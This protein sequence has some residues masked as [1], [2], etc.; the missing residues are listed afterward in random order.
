LETISSRR[1]GAELLADA[2]L[3]RTFEQFQ[4]KPD[5]FLP[6]PDSL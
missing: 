3:K 1:A 6:G 4:A 5:Y 2:S